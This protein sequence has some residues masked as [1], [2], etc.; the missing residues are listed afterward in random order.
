MRHHINF[1]NRADS[2]ERI[3]EK[4]HTLEPVRRGEISITAL[5]RDLGIA[6]GTLRHWWNQCYD[7]R[8]PMTKNF[9]NRARPGRSHRR[10]N[11][12]RPYHRAELDTMPPSLNGRCACGGRLIFGTRNG[13][14]T[15]YC[16]ECHQE[17]PQ[18]RIGQFGT[19][20]RT[21]RMA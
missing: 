4:R 15:E 1:A 6:D 21:V 10:R 9:R 17:T 2:P 13:L 14:T 12:A 20:W 7:V 8:P 19:E 3:E 18:R 5:A 11:G 16:P